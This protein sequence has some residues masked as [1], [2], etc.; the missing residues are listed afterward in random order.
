MGTLSI[1][2]PFTRMIVVSGNGGGKPILF[3]NE[4][5]KSFLP[6]VR[7]LWCCL[8]F[9]KSNDLERLKQESAGIPTPPSKCLISIKENRSE[10]IKSYVLL[11]LL[12][13]RSIVRNI[14]YLCLVL[15]QL[16]AAQLASMQVSPG[17][18]MP[19]TPQPPNTTGA[20]S[21]TGMKN[22][23]RGTSPVTQV[24]VF[25]MGGLKLDLENGS[26]IN[27]TLW[28]MCLF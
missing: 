28:S 24:K 15:Q 26:I 13:L 4:I 27:G 25:L 12:L 1:H 6:D 18:K 5:K 10:A 8:A 17:A 21:P 14:L 11:Q 23:K 16:Y 20:L 9:F 22:E 2:F 19:T 7:T 3:A